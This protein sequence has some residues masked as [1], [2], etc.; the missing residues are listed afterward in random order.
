MRGR[1]DDRLMQEPRIKR[2]VRHPRRGDAEPDPRP[3]PGTA[4]SP[5]RVPTPRL[6]DRGGRRGD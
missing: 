3:H 2:V 5:D 6:P 4:P 1:T